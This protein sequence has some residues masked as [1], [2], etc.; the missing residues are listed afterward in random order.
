[1]LQGQEDCSSSPTNDQLRSRR[2]D[3][4]IIMKKNGDITIKGGKVNVKAS[5]DLILKGSAIKEN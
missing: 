2:E 4:E 5:G 1:M 3:D